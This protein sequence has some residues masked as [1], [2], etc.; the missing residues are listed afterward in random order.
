MHEQDAAPGLANRLAVR[1]GARAAVSLPDT[2]L[3][4]AT[5]TGNPVRPAIAARASGRR[6]APPLVAVVGGA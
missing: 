1:L 5:L 6:S 3:P 2:P 4:G